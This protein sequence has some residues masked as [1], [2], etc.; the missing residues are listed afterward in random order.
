VI[1]RSPKR[2]ANSI[3]EYEEYEDDQTTQALRDQMRD[4]NAWLH[5][6]DIT[7]SHPQVNLSDVS[8]RW[9]DLRI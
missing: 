4:I 1:L 3:A 2:H 5:A 7:C 8:T 9:T 6:A